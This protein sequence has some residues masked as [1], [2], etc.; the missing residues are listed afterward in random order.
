M[1][2]PPLK[3]DTATSSPD[4]NNVGTVPVTPSQLKT[5]LTEAPLMYK[6]KL[7]KDAEKHILTNC[8]RSLWSNDLDLMQKYF[9]KEGLSDSDNLSQLL[10]KYNLFGSEE[11]DHDEQH[12]NQQNLSK[13]DNDEPEYWENQ[14]GK[15][16]G[17][18]F[19]K[20]ESVYRCR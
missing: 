7:H 3:Q 14:R 12:H 10:E 19:K 8:Y 9:F 16:C 13:N 5:F 1:S 11:Q 4:M 15:Q 20:G 2:R 17:H 18:L 6:S